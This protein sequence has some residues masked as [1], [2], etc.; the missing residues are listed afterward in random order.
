MTMRAVG[1]E[2]ITAGT[3]GRTL[4]AGALAFSFTAGTGCFA[5]IMGR[6][7]G[8]TMSFMSLPP[9]V[10]PVL[11]IIAHDARAV[12]CQFDNRFRTKSLA[13]KTL[14]FSAVAFGHSM[15]K[16]IRLPFPMM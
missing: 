9:V 3:I 2:S 14:L 11:H 12:L 8:L 16:K 15:A 13:L 4:T 5:F 10:F 1:F 7:V 6:F